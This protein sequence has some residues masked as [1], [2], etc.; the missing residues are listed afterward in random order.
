MMRLRISEQTLSIIP[1]AKE[2]TVS[3]FL[4]MLADYTNYCLLLSGRGMSDDGHFSGSGATG[5]YLWQHWT[6]FYLSFLYYAW[7]DFLSS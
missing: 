5:S 3:Y 6:F 2:K 1:L 4:W 7:H